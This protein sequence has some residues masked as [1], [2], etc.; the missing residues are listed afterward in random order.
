M[1]SV[2]VFGM[3]FRLINLF[4]EVKMVG[5]VGCKQNTL[6]KITASIDT[7]RATPQRPLV[8]NLHF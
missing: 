3:E 4:L 1:K 2:V 7:A 5:A 6:L 8:V